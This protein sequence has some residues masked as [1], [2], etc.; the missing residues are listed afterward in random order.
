[1]TF[2]NVVSFS[3]TPVPTGATG[4]LNPMRLLQNSANVGTTDVITPLSGR[5]FFAG[6][7]F[8][9]LRIRSLSCTIRPNIMPS[10]ATNFQVYA[11]WDRYGSVDA[12]S[13]ETSYSIQTDPSAKTVTWTSGGSGSPLRT[14]IYS[15]RQDRYQYMPIEHESNLV[16]WHVPTSEQNYSSTTPFFPILL[17]SFFATSAPTQDLSVFITTRAVIEFQGGYSNTTLNYTPAERSFR[18]VPPPTPSVP[19]VVTEPAMEVPLE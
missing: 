18:R 16:S 1:M 14:Y 6:M 4:N 19:S 7:M 8:D 9:R 3:V 12:V 11:A 13:T 15:T 17:L 2:T 10:S 5:L